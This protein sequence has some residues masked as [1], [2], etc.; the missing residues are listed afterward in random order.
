MRALVRHH[1]SWLR[2]VN[3]AVMMADAWCSSFPTLI[4]HALFFLLYAL[5]YL[6]WSAFHHYAEIGNEQGVRHSSQPA[7][8]MIVRRT[9]A[10]CTQH[11]VRI[12]TQ[13]C[14]SITLY[15]HGRSYVRIW[16]TFPLHR[17]AYC[18]VPIPP[19]D[20]YIYLPLNW[21]YP[22]AVAQLAFLILIVAGE[23]THSAARSTQRTM[24]CNEPVTDC[25]QHHGRLGALTRSPAGHRGLLV[26]D[27]TA[28]EEHSGARCPLLR[29]VP[30]RELSASA[31]LI[32]GPL[33]C[34]AAS[35]P[36]SQPSW[37]AP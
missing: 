4:A 18:A 15:L 10:I 25:C 30:A 9:K 14:A 27:A 17:S 24:Q 28:L 22:Q 2:R 35:Q 29:R 33:Q 19:G 16:R 13:D 20:R 32:N 7:R 21:K 1:C 12:C 26:H 36:A 31:S 8:Q 3:F 11:C 34:S 6:L 5:S 23:C 37:L